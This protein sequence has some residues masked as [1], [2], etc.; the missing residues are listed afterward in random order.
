MRLIV[1]WSTAG[2]GGHHACGNAY[3]ALKDAGYDPEVQKAYSTRL[4]PNA[5]QLTAGRKE[6]VRR[7]GKSDVPVLIL[8]DDTT[9]AGAKAIVDWARENPAAQAGAPSPKPAA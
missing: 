3:T 6:A 7:T 5:L 8:G 4:V 2:G 9:V 1:C